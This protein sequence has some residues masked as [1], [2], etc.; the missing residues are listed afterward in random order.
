MIA[1][2]P[3]QRRRPAQEVRLDAVRYILF[4]SDCLLNLFTSGHTDRQIARTVY[5]R[6]QQAGFAP[7]WCQVAV[8]TARQIIFHRNT[9]LNNPDLDAASWR[10]L[11]PEIARAKDREISATLWQYVVHDVYFLGDVGRVAS[12]IL[13]A[14]DI[15]APRRRVIA[16]AHQKVALL[17]TRVFSAHDQPTALAATE[18]ARNLVRPRYKVHVRLPRIG[19]WACGVEFMIGERASREE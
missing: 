8:E 19:A 13:C 1:D 16:G 6:A 11:E 4:S 2:T 14:D 7:Y 3:V 12:Y 5:D 18:R 9:S 15:E 17:I 10:E